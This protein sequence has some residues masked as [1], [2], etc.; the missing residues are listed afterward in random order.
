MR[1]LLKYLII[2]LPIFASITLV[3]PRSAA[4]QVLRYEIYRD[5]I[6]SGWISEFSK[7]TYI[8]CI[9]LKEPYR[10]QFADF[11]R[12]NIGKKLEVVQ[13]GKLLTNATIT[14]MID[15]GVIGIGDSN[16]KKGAIDILRGVLLCPK[17]K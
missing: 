5:Q 10:S 14:T 15:S 6:E 8:V 7:G 16:S 9:K 17:Y 3:L 12:Q 13:S 2:A 4:C 1:K 11:T